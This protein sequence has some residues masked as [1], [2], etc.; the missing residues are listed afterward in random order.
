MRRSLVALPATLFVL[1]ALAGCDRTASTQGADGNEAAA[2][3]RE[4]QPVSEQDRD[5]V[6]E[7]LRGKEPPATA[8]LPDG[9]P[10]IPSGAEAATPSAPP[11]DQGLPAGHP[12]IDGPSQPVSAGDLKFDAPD[13]WRSETPDNDMRKAQYVIP[14]EAGG[15]DGAVI[16]FYFG[17]GGGDVQSNFD[18]WRGMFTTSAGE[19]LPDS[20]VVQDSFSVDGRP[21]HVIDL[22]G[23][24]QQRMMPGQPVTDVK[25]NWRM[26]GAI[27]ESESGPWFIRAIG[28]ETVIGDNREPIL[29]FVRSAH[30]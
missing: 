1:G 15:E 10:P 4:Q 5:A 21:M 28:P 16:V 29:E 3:A 23:Q 8:A 6:V 27:V 26:I 12:P 11:S 17:G 19:P 2:T 14:N 25:E 13:A 24:Y 22:A 30:R 9:H 7:M 20:A 18:R